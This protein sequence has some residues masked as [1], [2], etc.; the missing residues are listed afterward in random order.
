MLVDRFMPRPRPSMASKPYC[1]ADGVKLPGIVDISAVPTVVRVLEATRVQN[2]RFFLTDMAPPRADPTAMPPISGS[3]RM[4][5]LTAS[6]KLTICAR[7]GMLT[8]VIKITKPVRM[9]QLL[10]YC[11]SWSLVNKMKQGHASART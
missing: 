7:R 8:I 9:V 4:P 5:D 10:M 3:K 1:F 2:V 6:Y 11:Q